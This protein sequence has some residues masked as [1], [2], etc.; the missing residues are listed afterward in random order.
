MTIYEDI[1]KHSGIEDV[2]YLEEGIV[3][4]K[5]SNKMKR[6]SKYLVKKHE[7]L[8]KKNRSSEATA[9]AILIKEI[10]KVADKF[11]EVEK[12]FKFAKGKENKNKAKQKYESLEKDF[13]KLVDIANKESTKKI[14]IAT[15]TAALVVGV[16]AAGVF[17]FMSLANAGV[18]ANVDTNLGARMALRDLNAQSVPAPNDT[19]LDLIRKR[20]E[21]AVVGNILSDTIKKTNQDLVTTATT[22]GI[23]AGG[24]LSVGVLGELRKV[25]LQNKTIADTVR[26]IEDIKASEKG[27]QISNDSEGDESEDK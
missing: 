18:L 17:G 21:S 23:A 6:L 25:G 11:E 22:A 2:E 20:T 7:G 14:L 15:G 16:L 4:F 9:L 8:V 3:F 12:E 26:A 10:E 19:A 27:K 5:N 1:R 13:G 24:V